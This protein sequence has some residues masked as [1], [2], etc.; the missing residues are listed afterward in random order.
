MY[1]K[2]LIKFLTLS[3]ATVG[4]A[5]YAMGNTVASE[6][7]NSYMESRGM[8]ATGF[9][10]LLGKPLMSLGIF[11]DFG[12]ST[13]GAFNPEGDEPIR[14]SEK[15]DKSALL[16]TY[17]DDAFLESFSGE[18][19][20]IVDPASLNLPLRDVRSN[21]D[22]TGTNFQKIAPVNSFE[23]W[24]DQFRHGQAYP[25]NPIHLK[26]L[27]KAKGEA[28][29]RC[30]DDKAPV[31]EMKMTG[32]IPNRFYSVWGFFEP[33]FVRFPMKDFGPIRPLGGLPNMI[34]TSRRGD[35]TFERQLN[36][37]PMNLK[38]GEIPLSTIFLV[39]HSNHQF[40][41]TVP[42]FPET[43]SF[44]GSV[45]HVHLHFPVSAKRLR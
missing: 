12:F 30:D 32:L 1:K 22:I 13:L 31:I 21:I 11:E 36:F 9:N 25:F 16:A 33:E 15:T 28:V 29:I 37:C 5:I 14:L 3:I 38:R 7:G 43:G 2:R 26:Q 39:Y 20:Y 40:G 6:A 44:P 23:P 4:G 42:S 24:V 19:P 35:A 8:V 17:V 18:K 10:R 45:A 41:G 34:V 27:L